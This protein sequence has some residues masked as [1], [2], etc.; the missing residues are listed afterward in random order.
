MLWGISPLKPLGLFFWLWRNLIGLYRMWLTEGSSNY[1]L[2]FLKGPSPFSDIFNGLTHRWI[3]EINPTKVEKR[4]IWR[5]RLL[6]SE[7][8][9]EPGLRIVTHKH[10]PRHIPSADSDE[11]SR[12][13]CAQQFVRE[14]SPEISN[15]TAFCLAFQTTLWLPPRPRPRFFLS[16]PLVFKML[17][18]FLYR[19]L[20]CLLLPASLI[21]NGVRGG[22]RHVDV[23]TRSPQASADT[24]TQMHH[25]SLIAL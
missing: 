17:F 24:H 7:L 20:S 22:S 13:H 8:F 19:F 3:C 2:S 16:Q 9:C 18:F 11:F 12:P 5:V 1:L 15:H 4:S 6:R 14:W 23:F 25:I 10:G 21:L